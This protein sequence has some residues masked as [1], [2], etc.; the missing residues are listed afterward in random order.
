[1]SADETRPVP[2]SIVAEQILWLRRKI[3]T[4]PMHVLKLVYLSHG[5]M[6]GINGTPLIDEGVEAWTYGPVVPSIY[7]RYK[8]FGASTIGNRTTDRSEVLP[9][10]AGA[11]V[12][13]IEELYRSLTASQLSRLTHMAGTPWDVTRRKDGIGAVIPN[14]RIEAHYKGLLRTRQRI[15]R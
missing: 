12:S 13:V 7:H 8:V 2:P 3:D 1:M 9:P 11:L 6:L 5:W 4:T 15:R 10:I 14:Q